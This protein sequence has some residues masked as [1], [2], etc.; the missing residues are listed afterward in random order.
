MESTGLYCKLDCC[1]RLKNHHIPTPDNATVTLTLTL[2]LQ[3]NNFFC[4]QLLHIMFVQMNE[5]LLR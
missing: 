2:P 5:M 3:P 1:F 4:H